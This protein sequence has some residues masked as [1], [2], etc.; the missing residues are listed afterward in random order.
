MSKEKVLV[1][2]EAGVNHNGSLKLAIELVDAA[3]AAGAD[4]VKFQTFVAE[5]LASP[6]AKQAEY[7]T[8][9]TNVEQSQLSMLKSL[10]LSFEEHKKVQEYCQSAGIEYLSTAFDFSSLNFLFFFL[11]KRLL[12]ILFI[13]CTTIT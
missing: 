13:L 11:L 4:I 12:L 7:Q 5:E 1:I 10:E 2:A 9:N 8:A 3:I 6:Q